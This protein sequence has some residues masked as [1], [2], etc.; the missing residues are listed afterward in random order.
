MIYV[1]FAEPNYPRQVGNTLHES[2]YI[3]IFLLSL[4]ATFFGFISQ[5]FFLNNFIFTHPDNFR[6]FDNL[7]FNPY[8]FPI[9]IF[10]LFVTL[11]PVTFQLFP[12]SG[13]SLGRYTNILHYFNVYNHW[14][15]FNSIYS[16]HI[17]NRYIDRGVFE[18]L[19]PI[20]LIR[21]FHFFSFSI[22]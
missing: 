10:I 7:E 8:K 16:A 21:L 11:I 3:S 4:G 5:D 19:G 12:A 1:F 22:E 6:M 14:I 15:M 20:G 18:L 2:S 13:F 9:F 17:L